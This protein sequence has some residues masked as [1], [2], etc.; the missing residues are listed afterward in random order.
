MQ[1]STPGLYIF[2]EGFKD[3]Y[4]Y[5]EIVS[6]ECEHRP[7]PYEV[8]AADELSGG[9]GGKT[10]LVEFFNYLA[11]N[12]SLVDNFKGKKTSSAFFMDKDVDDV[13]GTI[14]R[15]A[16]VVY[17]RDYEIE[18][19]LFVHGDLPRAAAAA[20]CLDVV[21]VRDGFRDYHAW[22][23]NAAEG[24]KD[25]T[26]LCLFARILDVGE[27]PY[28][29]R[30]VSAI[31]NTVCGPV[32]ANKFLEHRDHLLARSGKQA[33]QAKVLFDKTCAMVERIYARGQHDKVFRGKWY[34]CF[35]VDQVVRLAAGKRIQRNGIEER[36]KSCLA[37]TIDFGS[38]WASDFR[39]CLH[40]LIGK[41]RRG[42]KGGRIS[43]P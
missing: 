3:R 41:R 6:A 39:K 31:N 22:R 25:W 7:V 16:H 33:R 40:R 24:W 19:C 27:G 15:S 30:N 42:N 38:V 32:E 2:V 9:G 1:M 10:V 14:I 4:I 18:N 43:E 5:S 23:K 13:L 26:K 34:T 20:A 36:I 35:A 8:V 29:G 28:Y 21:S 11:R 12:D 17:T 37:E